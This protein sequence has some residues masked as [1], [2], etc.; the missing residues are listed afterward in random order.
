MVGD[1]AYLPITHVGSATFSSTSGTIPLNEVLVC[2]DIHKSLISI[3]RLCEDYPCGVFFDANNV[4]VIDLQKEK[5][6]AKGTRNKGLYMLRNEGFAAYLSD[7]HVAVSEELWHLRLGHANFRVLQQL[8]QR[9]EISSNKQASFVS[10]SRWGRVLSCSF[11]SLI[12]MF[13]NRWKG[14]IVTY[15]VLLRFYLVKGFDTT[16][17]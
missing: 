1:G 9:K 16:L 5:V 12:L 14:S 11:F 6:V 17:S 13:L 10:L 4:Y 15:G 7:R 2:P 8:K 3:S